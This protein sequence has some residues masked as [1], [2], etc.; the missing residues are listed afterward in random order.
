M[1]KIKHYSKSGQHPDDAINDA[2]T[3]INELQTVQEKYYNDLVD[4]LKINDELNDWLFDYVYNESK[5][6]GLTFT[7]YLETLNKNY[8]DFV[9][10]SNKTQNKL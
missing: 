3:F 5:D 6:F 1:K 2:K 10:S 4:N 9:G 8:E 7:E